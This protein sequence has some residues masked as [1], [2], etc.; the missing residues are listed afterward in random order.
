MHMNQTIGRWRICFVE[1]VHLLLLVMLSGNICWGQPNLLSFSRTP[2]SQGVL[3]T[4]GGHT[5]I[6]DINGDGK[7]DIVVHH[8]RYLAWFPYP[9][10]QKQMI[11][12]GNFSGDRFFL[13]AE[14]F[15]ISFGI[16]SMPH[17]TKIIIRGIVFFKYLLQIIIFYF[18]LY[19][20]KI[21]G[22]IIAFKTCQR[23][24]RTF[25]LM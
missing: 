10:Y 25:S 16:N 15:L 24:M 21:S 1:I 14:W 2:F 5:Q 20:Y 6:G 7:N 22:C 13:T 23:N 18:L 11:H 3:D 19:F 8:Q 4:E 12:K 17:S 9:G